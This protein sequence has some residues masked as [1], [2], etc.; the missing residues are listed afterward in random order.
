MTRYFLGQYK[1]GKP[2]LM[3]KHTGAEIRR[4]RAR[5]HNATA[6]GAAS[7]FACAAVLGVSGIVIQLAFII[8]A[9]VDDW[10]VGVPDG[11]PAS[12]I[13]GFL[14]AWW[15]FVM[16]PVAAVMEGVARAGLG[17]CRCT[18][19]VV[20]LGFG[21][22]F[23]AVA[24]ADTACNGIHSTQLWKQAVAGVATLGALFSLVAVIAVT[25]AVITVRE[26]NQSRQSHLS[27]IPGQHRTGSH[28]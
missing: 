28:V 7:A 8:K 27:T 20:V 10:N 6:M 17:C 5:F 16:I 11:C 18:A 2:L 25:V 26:R 9:L 22:V 1:G 19:A 24:V 21:T 14:V 15:F 12:M 4:P 3:P 13:K 23:G